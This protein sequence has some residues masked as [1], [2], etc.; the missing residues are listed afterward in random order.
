MQ[1]DDTLGLST[2]SFSRREDE[3][4]KE[5]AFNAK[6]KQ[7]LSEDEPLAFNGGVV[8]LT[9]K[10]LTLRQKGQ[11][12]RLQPVDPTSPSA[13]QQYVE[14]RARGAYIA[15][16]CQPEACFDLSSAA[17]HQDPTP[18]DVRALNRRI[19]W[20]MKNQDRGLMFTVLDLPTAR[21][22]VFSS[23][24]TYSVRTREREEFRE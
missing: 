15:S 5:A 10:S 16:I 11:A 18:D 24:T 9:Q 12:M 6:P 23:S 20:Q 7:V 21:L 1:T 17:Q 13:K 8:T 2:T 19:E 4:L 22:F 3:Q 14:Q